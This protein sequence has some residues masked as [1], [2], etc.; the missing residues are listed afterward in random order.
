MLGPALVLLS[1]LVT[2]RPG[3]SDAEVF[4]GWS[5]DGSWFVYE[6]HGANELVELF[7]CATSPDDAPTWPKVLN[8]ADRETVSG[9]PCVH[10]MD[11]N[12]A[13]W[14]WKAQLVLP[15]PSTRHGGVEVS[16]ELS[17]DGENPG[18]VLQLGDKKQACY[19][20]GVREDS[21]LQKSWFHPSGRF[22]A[23][24]IDGRLHH[25]AVELRGA[26]PKPAPAPPPKPGK[27]H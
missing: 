4:H 11:P 19:A 15:A 27:H 24:L 25:C 16:K 1:L 2:P 23:A 12:K 21:R 6:V 5:R 3:P 7:F 26:A 14:Q 22:A 10:F 8:E 17:T 20:S 13:P 9:L 18:F